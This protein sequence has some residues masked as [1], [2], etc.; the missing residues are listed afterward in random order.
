MSWAGAWMAAMQRPRSGFENLNW[1][2]EGF[3]DHTLRQVVRLGAGGAQLRVRLSNLYGT[4][5]LRP[6]GA[7]VARAGEGAAIV[8]GTVRILRFGGAVPAGGTATSEPV[9]LPVEPQDRLAV[10]LYFDAPTGPA[11]CH[12]IA[13]AT[14][15]RACGDRH[16]A[17]DFRETSHSWYYLNGVEVSGRVPAV[18]TLGDSITDG[19]LSTPDADHRYP[20]LLAARLRAAGRPMVVLNAGIG[21]NR[22]L[23]DS[24]C[25]GERAVSRFRRDVAAQPGAR[26][27]IVQ[28]G[29]NDIGLSE[30]DFPPCT[31]PNPEVG[32][33]ELIDGLR[34][35]VEVARVYGL[36]IVGG[37][38]PPLG[39]GFHT[40][41]GEKV[42]QDVNHWI[43]AGG[44]FD[45]VAD[46]D[47]A[48]AD[49][50]DPERLRPAYDAGEDGGHL[51]PNDAG[52]QAMA[53]AV[54]LDSL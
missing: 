53:D 32:A 34:V 31:V 19:A 11:T 20:D 12:S 42:R 45:A 38:I 46:F 27:V 54:D 8:P 36:R 16:S 39:T 7:T 41:R 10:T 13:C 43:R 35:L 21:G 22:V 37:T 6:A 17:R 25:F 50:Q 24:V 4:A 48:L 2:E 49:P 52:Y 40:E 51:H 26:T 1:S 14:T 28:L 33:E 23:N 9:E 3:H 18:V 44:A 29:T 47:R 30:Q 15:Y 5:P